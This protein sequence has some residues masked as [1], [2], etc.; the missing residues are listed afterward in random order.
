MQDNKVRE[1]RIA[2]GGIATKP[3]RAREAESVLAGQQLDEAN[4]QRAAEAAVKGAQVR[5]QNAYKVELTRRTLVRAL[6]EAA[7]LKV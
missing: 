6:R 2:L 4:A 3:W 1:A 5:D 7:T